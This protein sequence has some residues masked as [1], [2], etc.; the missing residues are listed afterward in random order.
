MNTYF[1]ENFDFKIE[2]NEEFTGNKVIDDRIKIKMQKARKSGVEFEIE[3]NTLPQNVIDE[4][5]LTEL[6]FNLLDNAIEAE[7]DSLTT[8]IMLMI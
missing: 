1:E 5:D 3:A 2:S 6:I 7:N 8:N 4:G